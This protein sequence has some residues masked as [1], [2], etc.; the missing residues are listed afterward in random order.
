MNE[1]G[2]LHLI[3]SHANTEKEQQVPEETELV[4]SKNCC[5]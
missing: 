4:T 5:T 2:F 1:R 3:F